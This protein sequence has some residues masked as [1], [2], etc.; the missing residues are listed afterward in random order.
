VVKVASYHPTILTAS[1]V[2][3]IPG[4]NDQFPN[5]PMQETAPATCANRR[6]LIQAT[7]AVAV[8]P[9][10]KRNASG[11]RCVRRLKKRVKCVGSENWR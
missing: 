2:N 8:R 7:A 10:S 4:K 5:C 11:V 1:A 9:D 6:K 3:P